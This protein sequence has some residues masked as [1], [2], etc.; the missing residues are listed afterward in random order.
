MAIHS[1]L[2]EFVNGKYSQL[3]MESAEEG[4]GEP[5]ERVVGLL[6][7]QSLRDKVGLNK[8]GGLPQK[9]IAAVWGPAARAADSSN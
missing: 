6:K 4:G 3:V 5:L 2:G 1:T 9:K 7:S 8:K